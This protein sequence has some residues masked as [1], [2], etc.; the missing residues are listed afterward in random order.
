MLVLPIIL[1][2]LHKPL[3]LYLVSA[4]LILAARVLQDGMFI[5][6]LCNYEQHLLKV[7]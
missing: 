2:E 6:L 5:F 4:Y 3:Q 7:C 1:P